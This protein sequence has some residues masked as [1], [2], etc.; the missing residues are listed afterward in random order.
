MEF[1]EMKGISKC[2]PGIMALDKVDFTLRQGEILSLLGENG[3]GKTT[4]MKILY[5]MY[6]ADAGDIFL[7]GEKVCINSPIYAIR[8]GIC[9]VHQHFMLVPA[10]TVAENIIV[11][12]EPRKGIL[13]DRAA[14]LEKTKALINKFHFNIDPNTKVGRLSVGEQQRVEILKALYRDVEILILDEPTA[15]LTPHEVEDLFVI[16][17]QLRESGKSIVIITHKLRETMAIADRITVLRDGKVINENVKP[18]NTEAQELSRMMVGRQVQLGVT[19][20]TE[21]NGPV[22]LKVKNLNLS[23]GSRQVLKNIAFEVC[24]NEI[25]GVAGIEGNGQTQLLEC[26]TG[27]TTPD[28]MELTIDG[29]CIKGDADACLRSGMAHVPEDRNVMGLVGEMDLANNM[30]LGYHREP[31]FGRHGILHDKPIRKY[32]DKCRKDFG[33]KAPNIDTMACSLSGGNQQKVV[34]ARTFSQDPRVLV[35]AQPTRGVDVGAMEYIHNRMLNMRDEGK[36]ILLVSADLDEVRALSD[37]L[38]VMYEGEIVAE[39]DP[40]DYTEEQIGLM[41]TGSKTLAELREETI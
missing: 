10:F 30:I 38:L 36:A 37:R 2:F 19:R 29:A 33:I 1:L 39:F 18:Q 5:G 6:S 3:A 23:Q 34:I 7:R 14:T 31:A 35:I 24:S 13:L 9:M 25:L 28:S 26:L 27:L 15:V 32:A 16:L 41:M 22:R 20:R 17:K 11:G 40:D 4:L 21:K 12:N 8:K